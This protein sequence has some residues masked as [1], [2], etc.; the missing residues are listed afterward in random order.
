MKYRQFAGLEIFGRR[1]S[2]RKVRTAGNTAPA[3]KGIP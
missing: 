1:Y 2:R 3:H